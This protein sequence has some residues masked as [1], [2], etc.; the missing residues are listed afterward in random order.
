MSGKPMNIVVA[1]GDDTPHTHKR[2]QRYHLFVRLRLAEK[3]GGGRGGKE[4]TSHGQRLCHLAHLDSNATPVLRFHAAI[5]TAL[6]ASKG[7]ARRGRCRSRPG[8][9]TWTTTRLRRQRQHMVCGPGGQ[10]RPL[11][12]PTTT[13]HL[14]APCCGLAAAPLFAKERTDTHWGRA[15]GRRA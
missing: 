15:T 10:S 2:M 12:A 1:F 14:R 3:E 5:C 7:R 9:S 6:S 13:R 11:G 4:R 8:R